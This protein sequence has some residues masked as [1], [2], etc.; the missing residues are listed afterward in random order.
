MKNILALN[1][2][3]GTI[4]LIVIAMVVVFLILYLISVYNKLIALRE[5]VRNSMSQIATQIES[6]WDVITNLIGATSKYSE[7]EAKT[8]R[9]VIG[10]RTGINRNSS[11]AEVL[12]DDQLFQQAMDR[13][14]VVVESYPNLKADSLYINTMNNVDK[15]ENNVR[16]ARMIFND[17]VTKYNREILMFPKNIFAGMFGFQQEIYFK[18]SET[19]AD[20]PQW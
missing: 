19:K 5:N 1:L 3:G 9:E 17:S 14:N 16:N 15:Y 7:H 18:N 13:I 2:G 4:T 8:L 10:M 6:R 12:K 20:M 11:A